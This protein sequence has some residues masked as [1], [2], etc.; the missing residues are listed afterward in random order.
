MYVQGVFF[1]GPPPEKTPCIL[2][3][4][5]ITNRNY[6]HVLCIGLVVG[7]IIKEEEQYSENI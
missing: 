4:A 2:G 5:H 1:T 3:G 7:R 6:M